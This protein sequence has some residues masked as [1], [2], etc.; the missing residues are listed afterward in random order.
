MHFCTF[1]K[2][3][4][5]DKINEAFKNKGFDYKYKKNDKD[6]YDYLINYG[7]LEAARKSAMKLIKIHCNDSPANSESCTTVNKFFDVIDER[8]DELK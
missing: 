4:I 8:L 1:T 5:R 3:F 6:I 2:E 7:S